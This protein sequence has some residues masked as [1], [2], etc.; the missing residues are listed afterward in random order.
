MLLFGLV[1]L[2]GISDLSIFHLMQP[3]CLL[4]GSQLG[5]ML[6][7]HSLC[8]RVGWC[9]ICIFCTCC[10]C[11]ARSGW[12]GCKSRHDWCVGPSV[13]KRGMKFSSEWILTCVVGGYVY[14]VPV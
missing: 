3:S 10:R 2:A 1:V 11:F 8:T 5:E 9:V 7:V 12:R 4:G 13:F 6:F 14:L